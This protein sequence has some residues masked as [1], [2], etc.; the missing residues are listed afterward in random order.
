MSSS[1]HATSA[2]TFI[3]SLQ[4]DIQE[5]LDTLTRLADLLGVDNLSF[6]SYATAINRISR[7]DQEAQEAL[8]R[9]ALVERDLECHLATMAH[10]ERLIES[11][12]ERLDAEHATSDNTATLQSR[13]EALLKKAKEERAVLDAILAESK[14]PEITF[15]DLTAQQT[16][17]EARRAAIKSKRAQ[18]RAFRGLPPNLELAREQLKS[19]RA[20]QME[21]IQAREGLLGRMAEGVA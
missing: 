8:N 14:P 15:A 6:S 4:P 21:L 18:I 17:N 12:T 1:R 19:A 13:R 11:W 7:R 16:A 20:A 2:D 10:E 9:L 3:A 5:T